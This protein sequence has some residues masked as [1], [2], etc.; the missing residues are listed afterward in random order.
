VRMRHAVICCAVLVFICSGQNEASAARRARSNQ[1]ATPTTVLPSRDE[2]FAV[3]VPER[4]QLL[5][6][7]ADIVRYGLTVH[8]GARFVRGRFGR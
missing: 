8:P 5:A 2:V 6:Y 1:L 3:P 4:G 7:P